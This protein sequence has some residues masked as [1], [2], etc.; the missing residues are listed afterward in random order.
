MKSRSSKLFQERAG[1]RSTYRRPSPVFDAELHRFNFLPVPCPK[2]RP[3]LTRQ[4]D[5]PPDRG[6]TP[7]PWPDGQECEEDSQSEST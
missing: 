6:L 5:P 7:E 2:P 1:L 4:G 3:D